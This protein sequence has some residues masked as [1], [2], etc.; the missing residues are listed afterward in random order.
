[1]KKISLIKALA[2]TKKADRMGNSERVALQQK[3]LKEL[4]S[5]VKGN[6]PYFAELYEHIDENAP[7]SALPVTN[8]KEMMTH[9]DQ[10]MTDRSIT[11]AKVEHFMSDISNVGTKLDGKY[12]VYT[13]S[14]STGNPCVVL[15]DEST[16]NVS[17]AIGV[18]RSFARKEDMT[19]FIKSGK[20][21]IALFAEVFWQ[22]Y[23]YQKNFRLQIL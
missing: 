16:I 23:T 12:L 2:L 15:Y 22:M 10:W 21:T 17:S 7:L 9:F 6:S 3:R 19:A 8:K 11:K 4:I 1:M 14:G 18:I 13:T 5:Y 20:K